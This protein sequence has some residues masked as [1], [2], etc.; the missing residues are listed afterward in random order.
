MLSGAMIWTRVVLLVWLLPFATGHPQCLD[1]RAPFKPKTA[2]TFCSQYSEFGCCGPH[3]DEDLAKEYDYIKSRA[4][5]SDWDKCNGYV[6]QLLCQKCSPYAAH[7]YD[8]EGTAKARTFPGLCEE[9]CEN[10]YEQC[11]TMTWLVDEEFASTQLFSS[12]ESFCKKVSLRDTDYCYPDLLTNPLLNR[13]LTRIQTSAPSEDCL[14]LE[15]VRDNIANPLWA[16]HAGDGSGRLF[17]AQQK[18]KVRIYNIRTKEWNSETFLDLTDEVELSRFSGDERG[19]LGMAFHPDYANN[20]RFFIFY[21]TD[22]ER[23]DTP[24]P[25]LPGTYSFKIRVSERRVDSDNPDKAD[26]SWEKVVLDLLQPY[27]NHNGGELFFGVDGYLYVFIGDGGAAGDPLKAGQDKSLLYGKVLRLDVDS[28]TSQPYTIPPDN[29]FVSESGSRD[30]IYAYGVRNIWRCGLDRGSSD[31]DSNRGR[32]LCGDVGQNNYEEIDLLKKGANYGWNAREGFECYDD[33]LCG[34]IGP[35]ELPITAYDH[36]VGKSV[37][38]GV[39]YRGCENPA[40]EGQYI[41]GDYTSSRLFSLKEEGGT[42]TN[43]EVTLCG[44]TLCDGGLRGCLR[45]YILS[46]GEDEDGEIYILTSESS[47]SSRCDGAVYKI[48][49]PHTRNDPSECSQD[50]TQRGRVPLPARNKFTLGSLRKPTISIK[51]RKRKRLRQKR[52]RKLTRKKRRQ[53]RK[54][55]RRQRLQNG[56]KTPGIRKKNRK[57]RR[58]SRRRKLNNLGKGDAIGKSKKTGRR[59]QKGVSSQTRPKPPFNAS[60]DSQS[61]GPK[62]KILKKKRNTCI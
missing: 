28:D 59:N 10:Y 32:V 19:F 11:R 24:P 6:K 42:W 9:F 30:E 13:N 34:N 39:F 41:Y 25:D 16:R 49:D 35:E 23:G 40:L 43:K 44:S 27:A 54:R 1:F 3:N 33:D 2:L 4:T 15:E 22:R 37:T 17:V 38:G 55:R 18:G 12:K 5:D 53:R 45:D 48:V 60:Q 36:S 56:K 58:Q 47:G 8:A 51:V 62:S 20:G 7:I 61:Q 14:C 50:P 46:F 31:S 29:P 21:A 26:S 57:R 52:R